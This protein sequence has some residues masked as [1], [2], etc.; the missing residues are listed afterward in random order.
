MGLFSKWHCRTIRTKVD[1]LQVANK[2]LEDFN[3]ALEQKVEDHARDL[4]KEIADRRR[5]EKEL[6]LIKDELENRVLQCT[7][8][9]VRTNVELKGKFLDARRAEDQLQNTLGKLEKALEGTFKAMSLTIE[10]RDLFTAG[11][12]RRVMNLA[13]AIAKEMNLSQDEVEGIRMAGIIHDV[14]K[15]A[16]PAE[17]L[18]KPTRLSKAEFQLIKDHPRMGYDI[19]KRIEF[20]WPVAQIVL[21]HHERMDGS[22]YPDGLVGDAILM[23]ARILALA[24]HVEALSSHR[25]HRPALGLD[26]A[27]EEIRRGRGIQFDS[28]VVDTCIK[29]FREKGFHLRTEANGWG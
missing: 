29:L 11:H 23:E 25:A 14:G 15:I 20:P 18:A 9:L 4:E 12:Q 28:R 22:G 5:A 16:M 1:S 10:L 17:I 27:M 8:E 13:V 2:Q 24:D 26:K 3:K 21:Q 7:E 6:R 19:L